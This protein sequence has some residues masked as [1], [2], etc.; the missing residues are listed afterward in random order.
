MRECQHHFK[1]LDRALK[2]YSTV[3]E[4]WK[5]MDVSTYDKNQAHF[6][7]LHTTAILNQDG[8]HRSTKQ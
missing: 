5:Y 3:Q 7:N 8:R 4:M 2:H 6:A 1:G